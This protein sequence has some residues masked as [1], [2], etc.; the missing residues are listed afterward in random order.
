M[1]A[2]LQGAAGSAYELTWPLEGW[3]WGLFVVCAISLFLVRE[4]PQSRQVAA[5][6]NGH[7]TVLPLASPVWSR[8]MLAC[9]QFILHNVQF[10]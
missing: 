8:C 1:R 5:A 6:H 2:L 9:M 7:E 3:Q 10:N 4:G